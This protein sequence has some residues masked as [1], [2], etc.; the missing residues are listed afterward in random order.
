MGGS[1]SGRHG[2]KSTTKGRNTLDVR[3]LQRDGVLIPGS[4]FTSSWTRNGKPNG[5]ISV[6]VN[7]DSVWLIYRHGG[8]AGQDM[9]YRVRIEHTPCN[10]GGQRTWW[11][12]PC[13]GKRVALL[14]SGKMFSCRHCQQ[15]TYQSTRTGESSKPFERADKLRRR[16]GWCAGVANPQGDKPKG[17]HWK[18]YL[19]LMNELNRHSIAAWQSTDEMVKR[20]TG[21]LAGIGGM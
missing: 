5:S 12:C 3:K 16:M 6:T 10:Y 20:L 17:M 9:N 2:G 19:R 7:E 14:Y 8:A 4:R 15:L 21:R 11:L 18:T 13:C 1:N